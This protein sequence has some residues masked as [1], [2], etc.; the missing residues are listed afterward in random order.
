MIQCCNVYKSSIPILTKKNQ[1]NNGRFFLA[2][3][4]NKRF[5][6]EIELL[7]VNDMD[8]AEVKASHLL[9]L[10]FFTLL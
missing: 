1:N 6:N 4:K 9:N 5:K 3:N 10:I 7:L 2:E 8:G